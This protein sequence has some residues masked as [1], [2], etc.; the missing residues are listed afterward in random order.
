M[1]LLLRRVE[2]ATGGCEGR[3]DLR[4]SRGRI[5]ERA[6]RLQ[7]RRRDLV[8]DLEGHCVLPGLVNAHD[9]LG[10]DLLPPLGTPPYSSFY[11]WAEEIYRPRES[12]IL[13]LEQV[14]LIDRL[15]WGAWRNV[16]SGATTVAH[17]DPWHRRAF[18]SRSFPVGVVRCAVGH[19]LG[20]EKDLGRCYRPDRPFVVHAAEGTDDRAA[21]EV[22]ELERLGL[23]RENTVLVHAMALSEDDIRILARR[24]CKVVWC[25]IS[26]FRLYGRTAPIAALRRAGVTVAL[27]TD[28]TLSGGVTLLDELRQ[29]AETGQAS[30]EE[31]LAMVTH[32]AAIAFDLRDGR[33]TLEIG[34]R[35]DLVVVPIRGPAP[36]SLLAARTRDLALVL[37]GGRARLARPDVAASLKLGSPNAAVDGAPFRLDDSFN[38]L[39][40]RL[41][42]V[43]GPG[44]PHGDLWRTFAEPSSDSLGTV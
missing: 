22:R 11:D 37:V 39:R 24:K 3:G 16:M 42:R 28:S 2:W 19:S 44:Y 17:H 40:S 5:V 26:N 7:H 6:D 14:P 43:L 31:L 32:Q 15:T 21:A 35:A 25:P 27:G 18:G 29:A 38:V 20:F 36:S 33:G 9:H 12:P 4:I 34:G 8:I 1:G 30:P 41:D 13:E 10:L 23:L